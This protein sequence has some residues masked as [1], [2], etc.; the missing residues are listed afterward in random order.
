MDPASHGDLMRIAPNGQS[1]L[2]PC[3]APLPIV[4]VSF[5]KRAQILVKSKNPDDRK[6]TILFLLAGFSQTSRMRIALEF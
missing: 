5:L 3:P 1:Q 4:P 6:S 2:L